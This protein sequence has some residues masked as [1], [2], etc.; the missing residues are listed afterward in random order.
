MD[1]KRKSR[2]LKSCGYALLMII[3]I[4]VVLL[5]ASFIFGST[6]PPSFQDRAILMIPMSLN[7]PWD[8]N[9]SSNA[10][11][12]GTS[13]DN[14]YSEKYISLL[15]NS[16]A[17]HFTRDM[18]IEEKSSPL[19]PPLSKYHAINN[20]T[21]LNSGDRYITESWYFE[22][23]VEFNNAENVLY[24]FLIKNGNVSQTTIDFFDQMNDSDVYS[25]DEK[26]AAK[27]IT[28]P[29]NSYQSK[30]TSGLFIVVNIRN[31]PY[32]GYYITYWGTIGLSD[33]EKHISHIKVL[34]FT[35]CPTFSGN[36]VIYIDLNP[37][38]QPIPPSPRFP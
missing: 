17:D 15:N 4:G 31:S 30:D 14:P 27:N 11:R 2:I 23:F 13:D 12:Y 36:N 1:Y 7:F 21:L 29:V 25:R 20:Y 8:V 28:Y 19:F 5:L 38:S 33:V 34:M 32:S 26:L 10:V 16:H 18:L 37:S 24:P 6:S 22:D 9:Q 3:L 35:R